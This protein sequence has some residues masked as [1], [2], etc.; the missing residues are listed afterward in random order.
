M[1]SQSARLDVSSVH[2]WCWR[3]GEILEGCRSSLHTGSLKLA[4]SI[5]EGMQLE[6][7]RQE[8]WPRDN[9]TEELPSGSEGKQAKS[10]PFF[11][12]CLICVATRRWHLHL[13][14]VFPL[15]IVWSRKVLKKEC[16]AD[17]YL[18]SDPVRSTMR[19]NVPKRTSQ[20]RLKGFPAVWGRGIQSDLHW[21]MHPV[22]TGR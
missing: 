22:L 11:L 10:K 5:S 1:V 6:Q 4:S 20:C 17:F 3:P 13:M 2:V 16:T 18:I 19:I 21:W 8:Q 9:K 12:H 7:Q 15:Y 14:G